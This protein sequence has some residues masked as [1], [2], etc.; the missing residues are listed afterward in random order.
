MNNTYICR[1]KIVKKTSTFPRWWADMID[2]DGVQLNC[3][4]KCFDW[5]KVMMWVFKH[6]FFF[7]SKKFYVLLPTCFTAHF[8]WTIANPVDNVLLF[9]QGSWYLSNLALF[10]P[11][12]SVIWCKSCWIECSC[13]IKIVCFTFN[14]MLLLQTPVNIFL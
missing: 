13:W 8:R 9:N 14:L 10:F 4:I 6:Q 2:N 3:R 1:R 5:V 12:V 11:K 7:I